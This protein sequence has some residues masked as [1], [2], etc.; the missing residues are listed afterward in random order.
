[1][2][3]LSTRETAAILGIAEGTVTAHVHRA[4]TA[5]RSVLGEMDRISGGER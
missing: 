2:L 4:L 5:L 1:V 3:D